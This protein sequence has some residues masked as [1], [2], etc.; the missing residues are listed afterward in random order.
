M[1]CLVAEKI[2]HRKPNN[3][4]GSANPFFLWLGWK[5]VVVDGDGDGYGSSEMA[6]RWMETALYLVAGDGR[7]WWPWLAVLVGGR[8]W[9]GGRRWR[10]RERL[11]KNFWGKKENG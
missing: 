5:W 7:R 6:V 10:G 4:L 1:L 9:G 2:F 3:L 8:P 11:G